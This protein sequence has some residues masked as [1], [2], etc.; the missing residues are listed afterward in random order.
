MARQMRLLEVAQRLDREGVF[1]GG[2]VQLFEPVGRL[3]LATLIQEG[4]SPQSKLLDV[5]CGCLRA[6]YWLMH[7]LDSG[8]YFGIEPNVGMLEKGIQYVVEPD[9]LKGKSPQFDSNDQ[10]DF[11]VFGVKFDAIL[12]RSVW[13]HT[14][15]S[16]IQQMLDQFVENASPDAFLLTS[17][18]PAKLWPPKKWDYKGDRW[19]GRDH[20]SNI[21]GRTYQSRRWIVNECQK[22]GLTARQLD[23]GVVN[24]QYWLKINR[25]GSTA[26]ESV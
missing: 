21:P 3:Q 13:T 2:P 19:V 15:K 12:A 14:S 25:L 17:Y 9:L 16:Q 6:G 18:W 8:C 26:H 20:H 22:R 10:F 24:E 4:L 5:G 11:S 1:T 23:Y 7:F